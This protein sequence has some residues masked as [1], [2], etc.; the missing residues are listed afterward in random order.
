M[1]GISIAGALGTRSGEAAAAQYVRYDGVLD[2]VSVITDTIQLAG[3]RGT[4]RSSALAR[5]GRAASLHTRRQDTM[6]HRFA[7]FATAVATALAALAVDIP[8]ARAEVI[9][10]GV[11]NGPHA[12]IAEIAKKALAK[13]GI[14]LEIFEFSDY[15]RPNPALDTGD[16]DVNS[17]QHQPYLDQQVKDRGYKIVSVAK[18]VV[19]PIGVYSKK[20]KAL[21]QLP[22]GAKIAIPNDPTNGGRGLLLLQAKGVLKLKPGT[23]ITPTVAD[24]V[25]NPKKVKIVEVDAAQVPH[26]L[27]DVDAAIINTN[28]AIQGKLDPAKDAIARESAESPY[29]NVIAVR[30]A[31][32]DKPW[33]K[34]L[35]AAWH[36][37]EVRS[38]VNSKYAGVVVAGF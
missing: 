18:T 8:A 38:Y 6:T 15:T 29:V 24:I 36:S 21:D 28:Y 33:V 20:V 34:K 37:E 19:F 30:K 3:S 17:F 14:E 13:Q 7:R 16:L 11:E 35:V 2:N 23:G 32:A 9:K 31:D 22:K 25:E 1:G 26:F 4:V 5:S 27:P 10:V 12:E